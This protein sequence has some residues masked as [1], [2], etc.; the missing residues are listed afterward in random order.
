[1]N[2]TLAPLETNGSQNPRDWAN[3]NR[4]QFDRWGITCL[5]LMGSPG[6]GKTMLLDRT[7]ETLKNQ[8][9]VATFVGGTISEM[10]ADRLRLQGVPVIAPETDASRHLNAKMVAE[11]LH[12]FDR[13]Y[14]PANFDL[15]WVENTIDLVDSVDVAMGEHF[16]VV[17]WDVT[18][19]EDKPLEYPQMFREANCV[20]IAK[21]DR[22]SDAEIDVDRLIANVRQ[23]NPDIAILPISAKTGEGF[24]AWLNW[25]RL[26]VA[27]RSQSNKAAR[28]EAASLGKSSRWI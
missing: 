7:L 21:M 25:V 3:R 19:G 24:E 16:K 15:V 23:I 8:L 13:Q 18:Q 6:A 11:S 22:A 1:M 27:L 20:L 4:A 10:N 9:E 2:S 5:A 26:Q 17:L 14:T 28:H 12:Q